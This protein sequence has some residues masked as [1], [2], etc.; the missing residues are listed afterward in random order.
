[1][2]DNN[3]QR[4]HA[5]LEAYQVLGESSFKSTANGILGWMY[6]TLLDRATGAFRGSQDASPTYAHLPTIAAR[7][8]L[9]PPACDPT[10]SS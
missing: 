1:M 3:A 7:R 10:I 4:L 5:Y 6:G 9:G 2:L 8:A